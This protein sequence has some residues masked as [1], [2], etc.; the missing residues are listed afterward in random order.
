MSELDVT[1]EAEDIVTGVGLIDDKDS[2]ILTF[3]YA[4]NT[5]V[6]KDKDRASGNDESVNHTDDLSNSEAVFEPDITQEAEENFDGNVTLSPV[7]V[8]PMV[9]DASDLVDTEIDQN[10]GQEAM[11]E[12]A[13][14]RG[15]F[16]PTPTCERMS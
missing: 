2:S 10:S 13:S 14:S 11:N 3:V 4:H 8:I 5:D 15:P 12:Y 9:H 7:I 16:G 6:S 1:Q